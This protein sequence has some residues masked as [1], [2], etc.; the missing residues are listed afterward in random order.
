MEILNTYTVRS[1]RDLSKKV[2]IL[3]NIEREQ[4]KHFYYLHEGREQISMGKVGYE[5]CLIGSRDQCKSDIN[6]LGTDFY[7]TS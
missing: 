3:I 4:K 2:A 1:A 6:G 5:T 7:Y